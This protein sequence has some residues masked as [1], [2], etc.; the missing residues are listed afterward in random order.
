M[1]EVKERFVQLSID[2]HLRPLSGEEVEELLESF[3]LLRKR[4][5]H[6][7]WNQAKILNIMP[8]VI[9][10]ADYSW[11]LEVSSRLERG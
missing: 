5:E 4:R 2:I 6:E 11:G 10:T 3:F 1:E 7:L 9:R 8:L